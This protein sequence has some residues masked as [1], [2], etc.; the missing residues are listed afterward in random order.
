[1]F[2]KMTTR[3]AQMALSTLVLG[4][5]LTGG[6]NADAAKSFEPDPT[7]PDS[8]GIGLC[9]LPSV[10]LI[11]LESTG[12]IFFQDPR[13]GLIPVAEGLTLGFEFYEEI[14]VNFEFVSFEW[15]VELSKV[16]GATEI[17]PSVDHIATASF[18]APNGNSDDDFF[19]AFEPQDPGQQLPSLPTV[20]IKTKK[21]CPVTPRPGLDE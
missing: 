4:L 14:A 15:N 12:Q 20:T 19:I 13:A 9:A 11:I 16:T 5:C 10:D 8:F 1:M 2:R 21:T 3:S 18:K 17:L 6:T 7:R